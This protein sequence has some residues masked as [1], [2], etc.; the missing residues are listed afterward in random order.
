[1]TYGE[2]GAAGAHMP[3][4]REPRPRVALSRLQGNLDVTNPC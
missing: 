1:M 4:R 2:A 3:E